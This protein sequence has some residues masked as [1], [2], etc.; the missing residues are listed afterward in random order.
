MPADTAR[1]THRHMSSRAMHALRAWRIRPLAA[2]ACLALGGM[3]TSPTQSATI[4]WQGSSGSFWDQ[5]NNWDLGLPGPADDAALGAFDTIYRTGTLA[6]RSFA[7]TGRLTLQGG[8]LVYAANSSI[9]SLT[10]TAGTLRATADLEVSGA[11]SFSGGVLAGA[12]ATRILGLAN[13]SSIGVD[14]GR[15]LELRGGATLAAGARITLNPNNTGEA[16]AGRLVNAAG[17][18]ITDPGGLWVRNVNWSTTDNGATARFDNAGTLVKNGTVVS[19]IDVAFHNTGTVQVNAGQLNLSAGGSHTGGTLSGAGTLAF[20]GGTHT[21]D[22]ASTLSVA[23]VRFSGGSTTILGTYD[24]SGTSTFAG[25]VVVL[26][27]SIASLGQGL[28]VSS[29]RVDL[30]ASNLSVNTFT[31]SGGTL[32]GTGTL[33]LAASGTHALTNGTMVGAGTTRANGAVSISQVGLDEGRTLE[34]RGG[35]T[36]AASA[37]IT[38]NPNN[39]G[40]ATAGRLVNAAGSTITDPGGLWVRNINWS[41]TDNGAT[42]RFDNAG[43]LVKNG[44]VVSDIDVAFHNTGTVQVNAGQLNL[45]AGGSHTGGTLSGAG[46]LAFSG[47]THTLDA[48]STLSVANVRFSGGS[49]TILGTYDVSGTS[50]FAGGVV[51]LPASIASLGQ[52]LVVSSGRVDLGASNLSVDSFTLSGGTLAGT[53]TLTLAASGTHV[54]TN[55]TM[56]GAGT[57]QFLGLAT[58]ASVSLDEGRTLELRGGATLAASARITLNP[59][60]TGEAAAG[61]L[62]NAAGSTMTDP[63]GLW[64]R[65]INWSTTDNGA[66]ARFDNAGTLVKNGTAASDI[67]AAFASTGALQVNVGELN[68]SGGGEL[69]G[70]TVLASGATLRTQGSG[71]LNIANAAGLQGLGTLAVAGGTASTGNALSFAGRLQITSGTLQLGS[72]AHGAGSFSQSGGTLVGTGTLAI[73][74]AASLQGGTQLGAGTTRVLGSATLAGINLDEG[75][76]LELRGGAT[77][78]TSARINL[79]PSG[80]GVAAAGRLVNASGST[81]TDP[82]G[83][84]V[85][86]NNWSVA[87]NGTSARF[88]NAGT[89][90]KNGAVVSDIDV[91]FHNTGTL[92][93][94]AGELNLTGGGDLQGSVLLASGATLRTQGSSSLSITNAAGVQGLGTLAVAGGTASTGN[95]LAFGGR[96]QITSGTLRLDSFAHRVGSFSHSAGTLVGTG[97]L[98]VD[99]AA[100]LQSGTQLGAGTTQLLGETTIGGVNLDDGRV[101]ELRGGATLA[102][103]ARINLNPNSAGGAV[104]GRLVNAAGSTITDPGGLWVRT[105]NWSVADNGSS[106]RFDNAGTLVKNGGAVSDIDTAF[107][108]TGTV[109]VNTGRLN[110]NGSLDN[111]AA[112]VLTGGTWLVSAGGSL[113]VRTAVTSNAATV[114]LEGPGSEIVTNAGTSALANFA[115]NTAAGR[116]T[117]QNGRNFNSAA[118]F[119]NSG[120]VTL[121]N[122]STFTVGGSFFTNNA[123][124]ML[125]MAGGTLAGTAV[126]S[127][128]DL[129][130]FGTINP[131]VGNTGLVRADG[132]VLALLAG[133]QGSTGALEVATGATLSLASSTLDSSAGRLRV[134]GNLDL[135]ARSLQV[136]SDYDNTG[137]GSGNSFNARAG[138]SGAGSLVGVGAAM[139]LTGAQVTATGPDTATL[140]LG[141]VRGGTS[142][143][144]SFQV[145]NTG[146][147]ASLRGA[148]QNGG[149]AS[150]TDLRLSGDGLLPGNFGPVAAGQS[151]SDYSLTLAASSSGGALTGQSLRVVSNFDNVLAQTLQL[152]GFTTVLAQGAALPAGPLDLGNFRIGGTP[153]VRSANLDIRNLTTGDGAERLALLSAGTTGNFSA[154]SLLAGSLVTPGATVTGAEV[155][156]ASGVA[157]VNNGSV[158][159]QFGSNG[160]AFDAS[161]TTQATNQQTVDLVARGYLVAQPGLP[162]SVALGNF[163]VTDGASRSLLLTNTA[164]APA[165]FQEA[166]NAAPGATTTGVT[167]TGVVTGLAA[168]ASSSNLT[169]GMAAGGVGGA[170]SGTATVGLVSNGDGSSGLGL[171]NLASAPVTVTGTAFN[172]AAAGVLPATPLTVANQ[173]V[174]DAARTALTISNTGASGLFTEALNARIAGRTGAATSFGTSFNDLAAG[175]SNSLAL[176]VGIDTST[177]G[178]RSGTVT[179]AFQSDGTGA[180]GRSGL[181]AIDLPSQTL[182]V[183]GNVYRLAAASAVA[184]SPVVFANQRVGG[185]ASQA[186]GLTNTAAADSFSERLNATIAGNGAIATAGSIGLLDAGASSNALTVRVDTSTA[187]AKN[188]VAT[189]TLAS[190]GTGTS[191]FAATGIGTQTVD[192]SGNVYRL[193][194][195]SAVAPAAVN[196]AAQRVGGTLGQ[197]LSLTNTAAAD[198]FSERLNAS[199]TG[200]GSVVTSGGIR[201]LAAGASSSALTV[202][203]DTSTAGAKSGAATITLAS[204]GTGTSGF[205]ALGIGTQTVNVTG[206]VYAPAAARLDTPVINFGTVRVGDVVA[207][208]AVQVTNTATGGL[209]DVLVAGLSGGSAPFTASGSGQAAAGAAVDGLSVQLATGSA[210]AFNG[211]ATLALASRNAEMADL[212]LGS[213]AVT[214]QGQVNN[215]AVAS[216]GLTA[217]S[218]SFSATAAGWRLDFGTLLQGAGPVAA[219]LGLGNT[220]SGPADALAGSFDLAA[221]GRTVQRQWLRTLQR[222]GRRQHAGRPGGAVRHRRGGQL[223]PGD[224]TERGQHQR[225]R[226]RPGPA[227]LQPGADRHRGRRARARHLRADAG[228]SGPGGG[229]GAPAPHGLKTA[230]GPAR[231]PAAS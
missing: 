134:A 132:G 31:L 107:R 7:G 129:A 41:T 83:L 114:R 126:D 18:T 155:N 120:V 67:D 200:A 45:S 190:D 2:A 88:D 102:T 213:V 230:R 133:V 138:V 84:W 109:Q 176:G 145:A 206:N 98:T 1:R 100:S 205:G 187:G 3:A 168:G 165:G 148:L 141:T 81:I 201:L 169:V 104:A 42:A 65:S 202:Q 17:S 139:A 4:T 72:F 208:R 13:L 130:G 99:G 58:L 125:Q 89:L 33:T 204:D 110:L 164:V 117:I 76:V 124:G 11:A 222:P 226:A 127:A 216:L 113:N 146:N 35:A 162:A 143:T 54:L 219:T 77:L 217:G 211:S 179:L 68:L 189:I 25:G 212:D 115:T 75:R 91:A 93:V 79:N 74:G 122:G 147:G 19:D 37:R 144:R 52:G 108:N 198:G 194:S 172:L 103:N 111:L 46:T 160:Q 32:A 231:A 39:T 163:R 105:T 27:A 135:G 56:V 171:F 38:L 29:G 223:Q 96:L 48:A 192:V 73:D 97:T 193:A 116:F 197:A 142:V 119:T 57:T 28:V 49:T 215:L 87:D 16:T 101:L 59:N 64:V 131:T 181:T 199:I 209:T 186:L 203:V 14:D 153:A 10:T 50:T 118:N 51:V 191:G 185:T 175:A 221:P 94:N 229:A 196:L 207:A 225:Q 159:L 47:G 180:N 177:A 63:G 167:L 161:F 90:I 137:S 6:V 23:N 15:T 95:A 92:Q 121:G 34:L 24:V 71:N 173:R 178:A 149:A 150:V 182:T 22:A 55:G 156:T 140:D 26:P 218:G 70:S 30:G 154:R 158:T 86:T 78:A 224:R 43:T 12:G 106:A 157:G 20:S 195:A 166:L 123:G 36:L 183:N 8:E 228:R 53:G 62:V 184:S 44:T 60:N 5:A 82:G 214:L 227:Q 136:F 61:R 152:T 170:R 112:G 80:T 188:G 9:G 128:G 210:G 40:E 21:L 69:Q 174:G 66:T 151:T 85:R 220:A